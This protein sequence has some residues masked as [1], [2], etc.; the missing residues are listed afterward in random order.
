MSA[1]T[2]AAPHFPYAHRTMA[3]VMASESPVR[4]TCAS[5]KT[6][7]RWGCDYSLCPI[8]LAA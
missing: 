1:P 2:A 7:R 6:S 5:C 3:Q 4:V 8:P